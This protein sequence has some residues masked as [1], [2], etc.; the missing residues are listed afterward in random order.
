[1]LTG[2]SLTTNTVQT[3]NEEYDTYSQL[4]GF[5]LAARLFM[6]IHAL[7]IAYMLPLV[8]AMMISQVLLTVAAA[9][10]WVASIHVE[11]PA[12]LGLTFTTLAVDLFGNS[13]HA[14]LFRYGRS[15]ISSLANWISRIFDFYPA[16]NIEHKVKRTNA[17]V[18]LVFGY[19]VVGVLFQN[20][21]YGLNAFLGKAILGLVQALVFHWLYFEV[22]G[23]NIDTHAIRRHVH[24]SFL[25][26][27]AHLT[28]VMAYILASA[29]LSSS[30]SQ[31]TV[32]TLRL[33]L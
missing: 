14:I 23:S 4:V 20:A 12:R 5:F 15:H 27:N 10:L 11:M 30:S 26:Q 25:W 13:I 31:S 24:S 18:S 22:D 29:A 9:A 19:S 16:I 33:R 32:P 1:V 6:G 7:Y 17:F 8:K 28:F 21:G 3:F 2:T